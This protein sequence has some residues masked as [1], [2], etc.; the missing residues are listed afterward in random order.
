MLTTCCQLFMHHIK[1]IAPNSQAAQLTYVGPQFH[2]V[3]MFLCMLKCR[4]VFC[5][6][7]LLVYSTSA[8]GGHKIWKQEQQPY[9]YIAACSLPCCTMHSILITPS[10][11][12][13]CVGHHRRCIPFTCGGSRRTTATCK[14]GWHRKADQQR[15]S[16]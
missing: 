15:P 14:P 16:L 3:K 2:V 10:N 4:L 13:R 11:T 5:R 7:Q 9:C 1:F 8:V 6:F 12:L